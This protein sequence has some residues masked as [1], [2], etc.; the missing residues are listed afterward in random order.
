MR[1]IVYQSTL[2]ISYPLPILMRVSFNLFV[3][4]LNTFRLHQIYEKQPFSATLLRGKR[5]SHAAVP[6]RRSREIPNAHFFSHTTSVQYAL[7]R[8]PSV[9]HKNRSRT[10]PTGKRSGS[11]LKKLFISIN[12]FIRNQ[13]KSSHS[14]AGSVAVI[15]TPF[16]PT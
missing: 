10:F 3:V 5:P 14:A 2:P 1:N 13:S 11:D 15:F 6:L 9:R 12:A 7:R 4:Q 8:A 16:E